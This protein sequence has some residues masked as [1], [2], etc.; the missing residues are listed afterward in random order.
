VQ[1]RSAYRRTAFDLRALRGLAQ[2]ASAGALQGQ[3]PTLVP[4]QRYRAAAPP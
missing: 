2:R 1:H 3:R 4:G